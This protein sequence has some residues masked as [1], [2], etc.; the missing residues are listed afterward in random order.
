MRLAKLLGNLLKGE[1]EPTHHPDA[2]I[3]EFILREL[4]SFEAQVKEE[5]YFP[6]IDQWKTHEEFVADI[7]KLIT[8]FSQLR[9]VN[10]FESYN[11]IE[12]QRGL[13]LFI[14]MY[15]YLSFIELPDE[16]SNGNEGTGQEN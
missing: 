16:V 14:R 8:C 9:A 13:L 5:K 6:P 12:I 10:T 3:T 2:A 7:D 11:D 15:R 4:L 1:K